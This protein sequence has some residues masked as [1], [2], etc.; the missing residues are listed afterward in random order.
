MFVSSPLSVPTLLATPEIAKLTSACAAN[1][2][3]TLYLLI[4]V[5]DIHET[6][7]VTLFCGVQVK[8][9]ASLSLAIPHNPLSVYS[10]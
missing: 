4:V 2:L 5:S 1:E 8:S 7:R 3:T 9:Q 6:V 10:S